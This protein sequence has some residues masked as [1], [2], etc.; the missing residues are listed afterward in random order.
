MIRKSHGKAAAVLALCLAA[1]LAGPASA[2]DYEQRTGIRFRP[3]LEAE[4]LSR[5]VVWDEKT[6]SSKLNAGLALFSFEIEFQP[7]FSFGLLGGYS[8]S[9]WSGIVFRNVP[10]SIDYEAGSIGGFLVGAQ[11]DKTILTAGFFEMSVTAQYL[12]HFGSKKAFAFEQLNEPGDVDVQGSW[13]RVV[14]GPVFTYRGFESFSPFLTLTFNK[15]WGKFTL[16]QEVQDLFGSEEK[17]LD[18]RGFLGISAGTVYA[19][20]PF[21]S[22]RL[23]G[24]LYPYGKLDGG[25]ALDF[26]ATLRAVFSF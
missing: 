12:A 1:A 26:G 16:N 20:S 17:T 14:A 24:A 11:V 15:I 19:P 9:D 7:G 23:K 13:M 3:G 21:F 8:L 10:F 22:L 4:Y 5:T 2:Q 25:L 6:Q 18:G